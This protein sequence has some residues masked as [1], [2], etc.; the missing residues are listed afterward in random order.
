MNSKQKGLDY[1]NKKGSLQINPSNACKNSLS[2][3]VS[4]INICDSSYN[5]R[6]SMSLPGKFQ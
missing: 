1:Y 5:K 3:F 6:Y 4:K 2:E